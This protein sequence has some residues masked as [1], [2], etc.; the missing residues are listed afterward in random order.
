MTE[1]HDEMA[2][3]AEGNQPI[4]DDKAFYKAWC[5]WSMPLVEGQ[6]VTKD[7]VF[8]MHAKMMAHQ[9]LLLAGINYSLERL[10]ACL[11][12]KG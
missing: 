7:A 11:E 1:E 9:T 12:T 4:H 6:E 2:D 3:M 5:D 10:V 8:Y